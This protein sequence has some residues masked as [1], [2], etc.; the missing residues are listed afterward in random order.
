MK[1]REEL[2]KHKEELSKDF[3]SFNKKMLRRSFFTKAAFLA[4]Y[5]LLSVLILLRA[6]RV[7]EETAVLFLFYGYVLYVFCSS[8]LRLLGFDKIVY[9]KKRDYPKLYALIEKT[10]QEMGVKK[11]IKFL[12]RKNAVRV[13]VKSCCLSTLILV[14]FPSLP[15]AKKS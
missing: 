6:Y 8:F 7:T 13:S 5:V 14:W 11:K 1:I 2:L 12:F 3:S 15:Q 4:V 9:A 10:A